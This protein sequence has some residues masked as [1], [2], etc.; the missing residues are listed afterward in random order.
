MQPNLEVTVEGT[1]A[2]VHHV[3]ADLALELLR[4]AVQL[5]NARRCARYGTPTTP[6]Q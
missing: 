1:S 6:S 5:H 4:E 3:A 2:T